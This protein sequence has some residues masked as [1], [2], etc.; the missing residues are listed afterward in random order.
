[1]GYAKI[2]VILDHY[3]PATTENAAR[4]HHLLRSFARKHGMSLF[5]MEGVCHQLMLEKFVLPATSSSAPILTRA[6]TEA[7]ALSP[8]ASARRTAP[9]RWL[10][11]EY[12]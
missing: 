6:R 10:P 2:A 1:M 8:P 4:V 9:R 12:G 3:V 11:G 5:D 7:S